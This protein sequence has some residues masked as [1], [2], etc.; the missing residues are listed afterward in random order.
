MGTYD[1]DARR[2][3]PEAQEDLRRRVMAAVEDGM[4]HSE[5]ER[6]FGVSRESVGRWAKA[7]REQGKRGLRSRT[8]GQRPQVQQALTARA[9]R[10][11]ARAIKDHVPA[12]F[13]LSGF[14]WTRALVADLIETRHG[15]RLSLPTIGKYLAAW[16]LSFQKPV[17]RAYERDPQKVRAW[18]QEA[19]PAIVKQARKDKGIILWADQTGLR[20]DHVTGRTWGVVGSTPEVPVT[21]RR[22][23]LSVMSA[24]SNQGKVFFTVYTGGMDAAFFIA[25]LDRLTR[26][27][28]CKVHLI[29]DR[30]PGHVAKITR[31]WLA[32]HAESIEMHFLP[33]Y[34]PHLNPTEILNADLKR[35][36]LNGTRPTSLLEL[37]EFTRSYLHRLQK[38]PQRI[39]SFFGKEPVR[40]AAA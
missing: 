25:F 10:R 2:L 8:R 31:T 1:R 34:S 14:L 28:G 5:A 17:R 35:A 12:D 37:A 20:S 32:D 7:V 27:V 3:S 30:H 18:L 23:G 22:F 21:G 11:L 19:Y 38:T 29:V 26:T 39:C 16:G 33:G 36:V 6:V 24:I 40:Y 15:I 9:Q 13:G 4:S